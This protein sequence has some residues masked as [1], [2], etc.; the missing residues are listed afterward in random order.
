MDRP[1]RSPSTEAWRAERAWFE[2]NR[3]TPEELDRL[4]EQTVGHRKL[5]IWRGLLW[6]LPRSASILEVGSG[7]GLQLEYLRVLGF[8]HLFG[9]DVN[10]AALSRNP[11]ALGEC[12]ADKLPWLDRQFDLVLTSGL[13][14]HIPPHELDLVCAEIARVASRWVAGYEY[15]AYLPT[16]IR[17]HGQDG[18]LWKADYPSYYKRAAGLS[19]AKSWL[20]PHING[21]GN[22]DHAFLMT[23]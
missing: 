8:R 18:R 17:W 13:L 16:P 6:G 1:T 10:A 23:R 14:I 20:L 21:S 4:S 5:A 19:L 3:R 11:Y 22:A 7:E 15:H 12:P 2:R 9:C